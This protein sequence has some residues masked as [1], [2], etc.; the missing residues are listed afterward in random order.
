MLKENTGRNKTQREKNL[1]FI[2][3]NRRFLIMPWIEVQNLST[4]VLDKVKKRIN[5]DW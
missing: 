1:L 3:N 2:I 4:Y 5:E